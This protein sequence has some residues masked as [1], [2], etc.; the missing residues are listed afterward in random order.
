M[1]DQLGD[2]H[3]SQAEEEGL[4]PGGGGGAKCVVGGEMEVQEEEHSAGRGAR[5]LWLSCLAWPDPV[6]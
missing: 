4:G 6:S 5:L 1:I 3:G 2:A